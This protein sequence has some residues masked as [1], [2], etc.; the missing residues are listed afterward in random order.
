MMEENKSQADVKQSDSAVDHT[1]K[2]KSPKNGTVA[3]SASTTNSHKKSNSKKKSALRKM[4]ENNEKSSDVINAPDIKAEAVKSKESEHEIAKENISGNEKEAKTD[5]HA[6]YETEQLILKL[7]ESNKIE[8]TVTETDQAVVEDRAPKAE[9]PEIK[10]E[11]TAEKEIIESDVSKTE[12]EETVEKKIIESNISKTETEETIKPEI[13][14]S[15]TVGNSVE[16]EKAKEQSE[17]AAVIEK[18]DTV[19]DASFVSTPTV[20]AA[21][22]LDAEKK[23]LAESTA[24]AV[25]AARKIGVSASHFLNTMN[26]RLHEIKHVEAT[27]TKKPLPKPEK[28]SADKAKKAKAAKTKK[29]A[30]V[31]T[32]KSEA[33]PE[34]KTESKSDEKPKIKKESKLVLPFIKKDST[35]ADNKPASDDAKNDSKKAEKKKAK[36]VRKSADNT[37]SINLEELKTASEL[38][39]PEI[40]E[41]SEQIVKH[42]FRKML[43]APDWCMEDT[44][45]STVYEWGHP[46]ALILLKWGASLAVFA[47]VIFN[48][49]NQYQYSFVRMTFTGAVWLWLRLL[50]LTVIIELLS[51]WLFA[52]ITSRWYHNVPQVKVLSVQ[53]ESSIAVG[54]VYII[55]GVM[56]AFNPIIGLSC[57]IGAGAFS[58]VLIVGGYQIAAKITRRQLALI[59]S[60]VCFA[61][62][63]AAWFWIWLTCT[64]LLKIISNIMNL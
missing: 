22:R 10:A 44:A 63:F 31:D 56:V 49:V 14:E 62:S 54:A 16:F 25:E 36:K 50:I 8:P 32:A 15:S 3:K 59:N 55:A 38:I 7:E 35:A 47:Y 64:D 4:S 57:M 12:K 27:D 11:E 52:L 29:I 39:Q 51:S 41:S 34:V 33:K 40:D 24:S 21:D 1:S 18:E 5:A 43:T 61:C 48:A 6:F 46:L 30:V 26:D 13:K 60:L 20:P 9:V 58:V 53:A 23:T 2:A 37:Q 19:Q 28:L 45:K 17:T 42:T